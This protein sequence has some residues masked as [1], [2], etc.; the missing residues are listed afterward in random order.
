MHSLYLLYVFNMSFI[1]L[2]LSCLLT[3]VIASSFDSPSNYCY[4]FD[5]K[6]KEQS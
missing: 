1:Y 4:E 3:L 6:R 2:F 5:I